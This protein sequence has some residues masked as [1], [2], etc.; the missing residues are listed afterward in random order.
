MN[1]EERKIQ[2]VEEA[3]TLF[4]TQ[5]YERMRVKELAAK[6]GITEAGIYR[7][8]SSKEKIYDA[9]LESIKARVDLE[10]LFTSIENENDIEIVLRAIAESI[11]LLYTDDQRATRL[12]LYSSLEGHALARKVFDA[13]RIPF[14]EFLA[15]KIQSLIKS[16]ILQDVNPIITARCFVGMIFDC[17]LNLNLWKGMAGKPYEPKS[18]INNNIP[19]YVRG[20]IKQ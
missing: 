4:S 7:H 11:L 16:G 18:L 3:F 13:V 1:S 20:L 2:I 6:C 17:S 8:F 10:N 5:G 15:K 19:I 9:V 14:V 12:L